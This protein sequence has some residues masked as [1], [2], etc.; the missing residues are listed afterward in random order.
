[1]SA[2]A[3]ARWQGQTE[4]RIDDAE[5]RLAALNG[6]IERVW[7]ALGKIDVTVAGLVVKVALASAFAALLGSGVMTLAVYFITRG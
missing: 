5:R 1:M 7:K 6:N 2:P 4:A 3:D